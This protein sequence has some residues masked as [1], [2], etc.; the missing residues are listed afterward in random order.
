MTYPPDVAGSIMNVSVPRFRTNDTVLK[1]MNVIRQAKEL[2]VVT[3]YVADAGDKLVGSIPVQE[4]V[5]AEPHTTLNSLIKKEPIVVNVMDQR[6]EVISLLE[7]VRLISVPVVDLDGRLRG[8][9]RNDALMKAAE[10]QASDD[11]QTMF[12]AGAEERALSKVSFAVRKRLPWLEI[13][14]ITAFLASA[15]VGIFEGH[16]CPDNGSCHFFC[17]WLPGSPAIQVR[18][19]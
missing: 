8:V 4:L 16:Y 2:K 15:V 13:N 11:L 3:L 14:L 12:G 9:I 5:G 10:V 19:H 7:K 6:S 17:P 18:K 1:A